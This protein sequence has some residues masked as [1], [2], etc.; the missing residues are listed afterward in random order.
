VATE[1]LDV[2]AAAAAAVP[3]Q[4]KH[5]QMS[6]NKL[7][8]AAA[9]ATCFGAPAAAVAGD[10]SV[11]QPIIA[12]ELRVPFVHGLFSGQKGSPAEL[13]SL[14]RA[15]TWLNSPPLTPEALRGK[16]VLIDFWT[17]TCINWL[18]TAPYVRA[19][20]EKYRDKGSW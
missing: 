17:Y 16:V 11:A 1:I 5:L 7:F 12:A 14:E 9:L 10:T 6:L 3:Q 19:W 8:A 4:G 15:D 20:A 18:R 2:A 13:R